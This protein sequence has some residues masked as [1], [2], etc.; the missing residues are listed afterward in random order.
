M[1]DMTREEYWDEIRAIRSNI[2]DE[3]ATERADYNG[4]GN[5]WLSDRLHQTVDGHQWIIYTDY[6]F[7]VLRFT[8]NRDAYYDAMGEWPPVDDFSQ[9]IA[10]VAYMAME[11]DVGDGLDV[12]DFTGDDDDD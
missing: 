1:D 5:E 3:W 9:M 6:N 4:D 8:D 11:T 2:V 7:D 10:A 12:D